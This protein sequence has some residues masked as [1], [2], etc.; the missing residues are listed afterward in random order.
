MAAADDLS[1][2]SAPPV[3]ASQRSA[4]DP[5]AVPIDDSG[6]ADEL[7]AEEHVAR[8]VKLSLESLV[9]GYFWVIFKNVVGW[10]AIAASPI[11]GVLLPGPGGIPLFIIGFAL[12]TFPGKRRLTTHVFRGRQL[13]IDSPLFTGL[14]TFFSVLVTVGLM[15]AIF[16]RFEWIVAKMPLLGRYAGGNVTKLLGIAVIALP[17]TM[18]VTWVGLKI[19]NYVLLRWV[20]PIRRFLR[21]TLRKYG[22]KLLPTRRRRIGGGGVELVKDEIIGLDE[23]RA[24]KLRRAWGRFKPWLGRLAGVSLTVAVLFFVIAPVLREW[25]AVEVR[26]GRVDP[27]RIALGVAAYAAG[28]LLFR[29]QTWRGVLRGFGESVPPRAAARVWSLGHLARYIPGRSFLVLRMELARPYG[30]SGVQANVGQRVEGLLALF[31]AIGVGAVAFWWV[32]WQRLPNLHWLWLTLA[33]VL[34]AG[35]LMAVP[36]VFYKVVPSDVARRTTRRAGVRRL[37][38]ARLT[39]LLL[40]QALGVLWQSLAVWLLI[41]AALS[42]DGALLAVAGAWACG[43]AAGHLARWAPGGIGVREVVFV[44]ALSVL[45]PVALRDEMQAVFSGSGLIAIDLAR[46][47]GFEFDALDD[48]RAWQDV[49]WAFLFFL[50]LLLRLATTA[51]EFLL[52]TLATLADWRAVVAFIR[53]ERPTTPATA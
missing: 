2:S 27:L 49:W 33:V 48:P 29:T 10:L 19:L 30:V 44:G 17:A 40:W 47:V 45:L 22:V 9:R 6:Y 14:I 38:W 12:V 41:G 5:D 7:L 51:A 28:L 26:I 13:P 43:W 24:R 50:A 18:I 36:T 20:P 42:A 3:T 4:V 35:C 23:S 16:E 39:G 37:H 46:V 34:A 1:S 21:R 11:L 8:P 52:A 25:E 53:G 31:A 32:A 15:W